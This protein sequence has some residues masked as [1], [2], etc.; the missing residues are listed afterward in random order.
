MRYKD[1]GC[2][3]DSLNGTNPQLEMEN[4]SESRILHYILQETYFMDI[5]LCPFVKQ[6][7][8]YALPLENLSE[9]ALAFV[10]ASTSVI[11]VNLC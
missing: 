11:C 7:G 8:A 10:F 5:C 1:S 9:R 4:E 3:G 6:G 2:Y